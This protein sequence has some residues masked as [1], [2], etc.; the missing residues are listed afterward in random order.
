MAPPVVGQRLGPWVVDQVLSFGDPA[1][2]RA[3]RADTPERLATLEVADRQGLAEARA[4]RAIGAMRAFDH[5]NLA[6]AIETGHDD[7]RVWL[8]MEPFSGETLAD[9]L[10][11]GGIDWQLAC[12][13]LHRIATALDHVHNRGWVHRGVSPTRVVVGQTAREVRVI[14][15]ESAARTDQRAELARPPRSTLG[16]LAPEVLADPAFNAPRA[17]V[18]A[19]GLLAHELLTGEPAFPAAVWA[20]SPDKER[21]LLEWKTRSAALDPGPDHPDWLRRLVRKCTDPSPNNRLPDMEAVVACLDAARSQWERPDV[22]RLTPFHVPRSELPPLDVRPTYLDPQVL[23]EA[24]ALAPREPGIDRPLLTLAA[25][26]MGCAAG[27]AAS[28]LV[29]MFVELAR[30]G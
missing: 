24:I 27:L 8:A 7:G 10:E 25:A 1:L 20:E 28:A 2:V 23:A 16:Y 15:L 5:E 9:R 17:D 3:H 11:A 21:G 14:G 18:Y 22:R 4:L 6:R 30:L 19:F 26:A 13:W 29:V 12:A